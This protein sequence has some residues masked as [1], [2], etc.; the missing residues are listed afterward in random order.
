MLEMFNIVCVI[1]CYGIQKL[2]AEIQ[3]ICIKPYSERFK[4]IVDVG[5]LEVITTTGGRYVINNIKQ[6]YIYHKAIIG[7]IVS[8]T[9]YSNKHNRS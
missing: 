8:A 5:T 2:E 6:P 4:K 1:I 9:H 7:I 3:T